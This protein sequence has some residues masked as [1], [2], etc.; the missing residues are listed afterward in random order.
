VLRRHCRLYRTHIFSPQR[1]RGRRDDNNLV[2]N[3][4]EISRNCA[5]TIQRLFFA[6]LC[7]L[8]GEIHFVLKQGGVRALACSTKERANVKNGGTVP[9]KSRAC[10]RWQYLDLP[11]IE[12]GEAWQLQT[13]LVSARRSELL[14]SDVFLLLEHPPVFT[15]GRRGGRENLTVA[16]SFLEQFRIPI[17]HVERGGNITYHGPGQL[18][19]YGIVHLQ[20]AGL[21]VL[22]YVTGLE[23]VMIRTAAEWGVLS[24]RN[25]LNRGIWVGAS[26]LGSIGIAVRRGVAF[27][28]FALN[29]NTSLEPFSWIN[30]CGLKGIGVTSLARELS[31][32]L[33][34]IPVRETLRRSIESV[35]QIQ[36]VPTDLTKMELLLTTH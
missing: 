30:P 19:G 18:V 17:F 26:K 11:L 22:D 13:R 32:G 15:L 29:V 28:G 1:R 3:L 20:T 9:L 4:D 31:C 34:I 14:D 25:P 2:K 21:S 16:E 35:F 24:E 10:K 33:S 6:F 12:Y 36:L 7:A 5:L 27:H 23:E 8:C